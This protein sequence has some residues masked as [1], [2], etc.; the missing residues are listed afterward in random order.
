MDHLFVEQ[1]NRDFI[2]KVVLLK[3]FPHTL[4][5]KKQLFITEGMYSHQSI[6]SLARCIT[7]LRALASTTAYKIF[8]IFFWNFEEHLVGADPKWSFYSNPLRQMRFR[9]SLAEQW[10]VRKAQERPFSTTTSKV[11]AFWQE[12][13]PQTKI[14]ASILSIIFKIGLGKLLMSH[15][16][17]CNW[18]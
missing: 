1:Q 15:I 7:D 18:L 14:F 2:S 17:Q 12:F 11:K 4:F 9:W 3:W 5:R 16:L 13:A 8:A 6:R 10:I